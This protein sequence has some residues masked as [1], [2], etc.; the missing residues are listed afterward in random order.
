MLCVIGGLMPLYTNREPHP[1]ILTLSQAS[2][3][4]TNTELVY[5]LNKIKLLFRSKYKFFLFW[6]FL[7]YLLSICF[8]FIL[9]WLIAQYTETHSHL[10]VNVWCGSLASSENFHLKQS[11][12]VYSSKYG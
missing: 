11:C 12:I 3:Y 4:D 8:T 6:Y 9:Q 10:R 5:P 2:V 7:K 1:H